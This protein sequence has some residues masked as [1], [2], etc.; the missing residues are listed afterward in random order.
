MYR[1]Q[2]RLLLVDCSLSMKP[3]DRGF[4]EVGAA[5]RNYIRMRYGLRIDE[6]KKRHCRKGMGLCVG[7]SVVVVLAVAAAEDAAEG[8]MSHLRHYRW[9]I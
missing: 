6:N 3:N 2:G 5:R 1:K 4:Q 9:L 8:T 7:R